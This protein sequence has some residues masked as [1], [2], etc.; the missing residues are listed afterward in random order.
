MIGGPL[1]INL[2]TGKPFSQF[3]IFF[4]NINQLGKNN[5]DLSGHYSTLSISS[6]HYLLIKNE[7]GSQLIEL[8]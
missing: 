2:G 8:R 1:R 5:G 6:G 4:I 3:D 7:T